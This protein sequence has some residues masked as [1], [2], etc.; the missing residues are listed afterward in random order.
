M[1]SRIKVGTAT[2]DIT[3][4]LG[5]SM[6]GY[7]NDR[8][9]RE[10]HDA[11][12][13]RAL[14]ADNGARRLAV[15]VCDVCVL[16]R[17]ETDAAKALIEKE[18]GIAKQDVMICATHTH[19][20]P[21]T[22]GFPGIP[23][24]KADEYCQWLS[25]RIADAVCMAAQRTEEA[26]LGFGAGC[27]PTQ[28]FNRRFVMKDGSVRM[29]PGHRNPDIV[30]PA[31]PVDPDAWVLAFRRPDHPAGSDGL[32]AVLANYALHYVGGGPGSKDQYALSADY[33]TDFC[34]VLQRMIGRP[35]WT[36]LSNGCC[37]DINNVDVNA[38][39]LEKRAYRQRERVA[40]ILA[41]EVM[42]VLEKMVFVGD[43][44]KGLPF[45][46]EMSTLKLQRR[47]PS[48]QQ[49]KTAEEFLRSDPNG[50]T[51]KHV[52][53]RQWLNMREHPV[54]EDETY[55]SAMRFGDLALVGLPGE[56]FV[57]LGLAI[58]R[59]SPFRKTMV[60]ELANDWIGYVP[61]K[62][63]FEEGSYETDLAYSSRSQP[64]AGDLMVEE[65]LRLLERL[66]SP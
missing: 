15:V 22:T 3:P 63:A 5:V 46:A 56:V 66:K 30:R 58:K 59:R 11:L 17:P 47:Q 14:V 64:E 1:A 61:T 6:I 10:A 27:E 39:Y 31:G 7:F 65:A 23:I 36:A 13:A 25:V 57:E 48:E 42:K 38:A 32:Q 49:L 55:I 29:N 12:A 4:P 51:T 62:R 52:Y 24:H 54:K 60:L 28:V 50:A 43:D 35:L 44:P 19:T 34:R 2:L 16:E 20:G 45:A 18:C 21:A 41:A 40:T 8:K 26:L 9:A 53:A 37:G 33:F